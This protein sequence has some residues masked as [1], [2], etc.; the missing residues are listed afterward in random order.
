M[1]GFAKT[2][3]NVMINQEKLFALATGFSC[4][5]SKNDVIKLAQESISKLN[6]LDVTKISSS[7]DSKK[8]IQ[9][10]SMAVKLDANILTPQL[11]KKLLSISTDINRNLKEGKIEPSKD[12][13]KIFEVSMKASM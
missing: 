3:E 7:T 1:K 6:E 8:V 12:M 4:E 11:N 2:L 13:F 9:N 10:L 5:Y